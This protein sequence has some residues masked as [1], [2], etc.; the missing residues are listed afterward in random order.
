MAFFRRKSSWGSQGSI[1]TK[2]GVK[3]FER[4]REKRE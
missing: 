1:A 3:S 2:N 4:E